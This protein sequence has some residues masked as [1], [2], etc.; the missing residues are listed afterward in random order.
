MVRVPNDWAEQKSSTEDT[1]Y[2]E[3]ADQTKG[4]YLST[5]CFPDDPR[6]GAEILES[7]RLTELRNIRNI[8]D[9]SMESVEEWNSNLPSGSIVGMDF[10][11]REASYRIVRKIICCPPW[12]VR[13][14][15]H[16]YN[17]TDYE[18]SKRYFKPLIES[19]EI[20]K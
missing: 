1:F 12:V 20:H 19:L 13:S 10:L 8:K 14:S 4:A 9:K 5:W 16:D 3:S 15:F 11:D 18:T 7:F 17:C 6:S 2:L